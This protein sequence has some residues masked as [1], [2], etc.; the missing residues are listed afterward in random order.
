LGKLN[1]FSVNESVG[2]S[3]LLSGLCPPE[4]GI[5]ET[6]GEESEKIISGPLSIDKTA[7]WVFYKNS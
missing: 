2:R 6:R 5:P 4:V 1:I 3:L 7:F